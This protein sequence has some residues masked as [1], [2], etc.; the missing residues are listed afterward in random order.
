MYHVKNIEQEYCLQKSGLKKS[1]TSCTLFYIY[2]SLMLFYPL[3]VFSFHSSHPSL[4]SF[5][6]QMKLNSDSQQSSVTSPVTSL[7]HHSYHFL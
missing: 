1:S 3:E 5:K 4:L 2:I 6:A 7:L